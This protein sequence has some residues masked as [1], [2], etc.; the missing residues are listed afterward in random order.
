MLFFYDF[1]HA[2]LCVMEVFAVARYLSISL[3][4]YHVGVLYPDC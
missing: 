2:T 3:S 4:V 1:Y